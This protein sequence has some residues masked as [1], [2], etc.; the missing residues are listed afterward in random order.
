MSIFRFIPEVVKAGAKAGMYG[1]KA[2]KFGAAASRYGAA[3]SRYGAA[4]SRYGAAAGRYG[5]QGFQ[6]PFKKAHLKPPFS[7]AYHYRQGFVDKV[8]E[9]ATFG[10][11]GLGS[12]M[13]RE[14]K[15]NEYRGYG[16]YRR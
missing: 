15:D 2:G 13:E 14:N 10:T 11:T 5:L 6:Y 4:A 9:G 3:A 16:F 12:A 7:G 8:W 1:G